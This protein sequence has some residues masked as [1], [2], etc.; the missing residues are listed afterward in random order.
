M[1]FSSCGLPALGDARSITPLSHVVSGVPWIFR[2]CPWV[3][4]KLPVGS[5]TAPWPSYPAMDA[6]SMDM[7]R[8][9]RPRRRRP[10]PCISAPAAIARSF[11]CT[12]PGSARTLR[13]AQRKSGGTWSGSRQPKARTLRNTAVLRTPPAVCWFP[14]AIRGSGG[15]SAS[16]RREPFVRL[17]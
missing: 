11:R 12:V 7:P 15:P 9:L 17:T 2:S 1:H 5:L 16:G 3:A 14:N 13:S 4:L 10:R 8:Q 6:N